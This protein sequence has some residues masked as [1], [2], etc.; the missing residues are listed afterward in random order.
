MKQPAM[1]MI[2][3]M[4]AVSSVSNAQHPVGSDQPALKD[5]DKH[6]ADAGCKCL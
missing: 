3:A 1:L 4:L 2:A 5:G 6:T